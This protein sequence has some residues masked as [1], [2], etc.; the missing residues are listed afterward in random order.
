MNKL[1][2]DGRTEEQKIQEAV[3]FLKDKGYVVS[4]PL[5]KKGG[6]RTPSQLVRFFY[7]T[8]IRYNPEVEMYYTG[9]RKRDLDIAKKFIEARRS[10][11]ISKARAAEECC[12]LIEHLFK[13]E[14][15][16]KLP[17]KVTSMA[18]LGQD[19][20][21]WVTEKLLDA[22]NGYNKQISDFEEKIWFDNF[23]KQQERRIIED[24]AEV[25]HKRLNSEGLNGTE[26]KD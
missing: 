4:G 14:E 17:F 20:M 16:L 8:F 11:G 10:T 9:S 7:E 18:V 5:L 1:P 15:Q 24:L 22:Y 6:V 25:S 23:Y 2:L 19:K 3:D 12:I 26:K 13:Y 21:A